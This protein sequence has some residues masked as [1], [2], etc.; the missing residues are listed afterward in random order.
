MNKTRISEIIA[1]FLSALLVMMTVDFS[2]VY[3]KDS[4]GDV[5]SLS[6]NSSGDINEEDSNARLIHN[7]V[8]E[9]GV[10][11]VEGQF[12]DYSDSANWSFIYFGSYPQK[13]EFDT[14]I[15]TKINEALGELNTGDIW[16]DGAKY[17]KV[18]VNDADSS[19]GWAEGDKFRY[20]KWEKI[21]W[22]VIQ[23]EED[24]ERILVQSAVGLDSQQY[25]E[26][27][28]VG[29]K[30]SWES[31]SLRR[32]L[33]GGTLYVDPDRSGFTS[34]AFIDT[35]FSLDEQQAIIESKILNRSTTNWTSQE[36]GQTL[37]TKDKVFLLSLDEMI[38][39]KNGFNPN[40]LEKSATRKA[41]YS[42]YCGAMGSGF[43][44]LRTMG[45][46]NDPLAF[47]S[48]GDLQYLGVSATGNRLI[49]YPAAYLDINSSLWSVKN[50]ENGDLGGRENIDIYKISNP[51]YKPADDYYETPEISTW[52]YVY[53]GSYPGTEITDSK[54]I[55]AIDAELNKYGDSA[56]LIGDVYVNGVKYR[57]VVNAKKSYDDKES[58][59]YYKWERIKW[60]VLKKEGSSLLLQ[61]DKA[62]DCKAF[63]DIFNHWTY[64]SLRSWLNG[65]E[66]KDDNLDFSCISFFDTAFSTEEQK[67]ILSFVPESMNVGYEVGKDYIKEEKVFLLSK[68]ESCNKEYG[69]SPKETVE[70][71]TRSFQPTDYAIGRGMRKAAFYGSNK[72]YGY[73]VWTRS[74]GEIVSS[75]YSDKPDT[76]YGIVIDQSG[77]FNDWRFRVN[78]L[79]LGVTP[80]IHLNSLSALWSIEDDGKS[81]SGGSLGV[82]YAEGIIFDKADSG[83]GSAETGNRNVGNESTKS[84]EK[85]QNEETVSKEYNQSQ[86]SLE[87]ISVGRTRI[88]SVKNNKKKAIVVKWKKTAGVNGYEV[89]YS[90]NRKFKK[91]VKTKTVKSAKKTS[92]SIKKLKKGKTYY[93]RI[94][95][96]SLA[97]SKKIIGSWSKVK[98]IKIKK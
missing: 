27:G 28:S 23:I 59:H 70:S 83:S 66:Q 57:K 6:N 63:D 22:R 36:E 61:A 60:R 97:A 20:F 93:V 72:E 30:K 53:F 98:K 51:I 46:L 14:S 67:D 24:K 95:G 45:N 73:C 87:T 65:Y 31:C 77:L 49:L 35:A 33:N 71:K 88:S 79:Y 9:E 12:V 85:P 50:D 26:K 21:K 25:L 94:R 92:L 48:T 32:W 81:G 74:P 15:I 78:S 1:I 5:D 38:S 37:T 41:E 17:R 13:E 52:S 76:Y 82:Q 80:V 62:I 96:Y 90:T 4:N 19:K 43:V 55:E 2:W 16:V 56:K 34:S 11:D 29:Y 75:N 42:D 18:S 64:S 7:P 58:Y 3:A 84:E 89:Q 69:Y 54:L 39:S 86:E 8:Y 10:N 47:K 68:E 91:N 44:G 40:Y